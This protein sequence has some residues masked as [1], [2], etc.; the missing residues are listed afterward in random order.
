MDWLDLLAV[1]GTLTSL[2]QHHSSKVSI[3]QRSAFF[4][5]QLNFCCTISGISGLRNQPHTQAGW[6][7][8]YIPNSWLPSHP[9]SVISRSQEGGRMTSRA[10]NFLLRS[11]M[12]VADITSAQILLEKTLPCGTSGFRRG[13]EMT[14]RWVAVCSDHLYYH[15]TGRNEGLAFTYILLHWWN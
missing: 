8:H 14:L 6:C 10:S 12:T 1:Q 15:G 4:M 2:L 7:L 11:D 13:W 9:I 3:L 5:V